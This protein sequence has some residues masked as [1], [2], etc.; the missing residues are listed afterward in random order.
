MKRNLTEKASGACS[1]L[2][3]PTYLKRSQTDDRLPSTDTLYDSNKLF[4]CYNGSHSGFTRDTR[5][6]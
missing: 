1:I 2:L 3:S 5:R 6:S 4:H